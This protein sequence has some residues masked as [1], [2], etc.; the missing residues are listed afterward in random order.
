MYSA[1][2]FASCETFAT[3]QDACEGFSDFINKFYNAM[4]R[5][6]LKPGTP[7]HQLST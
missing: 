6:V 5:A 2:T 3:L 1:P 4:I 7:A